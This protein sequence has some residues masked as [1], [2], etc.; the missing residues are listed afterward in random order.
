MSLIYKISF[1]SFLLQ[2]HFIIKR[3]LQTELISL[4]PRCLPLPNSLDSEDVCILLIQFYTSSP[5]HK[6]SVLCDL[7]VYIIIMSLL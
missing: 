7:D 3:T 2:C 1:L 4:L 6:S 5:V